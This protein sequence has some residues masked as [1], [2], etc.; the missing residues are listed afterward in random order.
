MQQLFRT[1]I[2][3]DAFRENLGANL[4]AYEVLATTSGLLRPTDT[5]HATFP[6]FPSFSPSRYSSKSFSDVWHNKSS[7]EKLVKHFE[8][9]GFPQPTLERQ[10]EVGI[11]RDWRFLA[12]DTNL[13]AFDVDK[14]DK[15]IGENF[16]R[17]LHFLV[18]SA[19][20]IPPG[21]AIIAY[22][23]QHIEFIKWIG[24]RLGFCVLQ[25]ALD[26]N[27]SGSHSNLDGR[28]RS[29][30]NSWVILMFSEKERGARQAASAKWSEDRAKATIQASKAGLAPSSTAPGS[31][32]DTGHEP[33]NPAAQFSS[34][35]ESTFGEVNA[36]IDSQKVTTDGAPTKHPRTTAQPSLET[37]LNQVNQWFN[38]QLKPQCQA[39]VKM[40]PA[41]HK[42]R[43]AEAKRLGD[44]VSISLGLESP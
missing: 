21:Q 16:G 29:L 6:G 10:A 20:R 11:I 34:T 19:D 44:L 3:E 38:T 24:T 12:S 2:G 28:L 26:L 32:L 40:P 4:D 7:L 33:Q 8:R 5:E 31:G 23:D 36:H 39:F 15:N 14:A 42:A 1:A 41:D 25:P 35:F 22:Y 17:V 27:L 18:C 30:L 37:R 13:R 9:V 43:Q